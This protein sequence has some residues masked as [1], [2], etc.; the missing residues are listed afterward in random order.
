MNIIFD[1]RL[2]PFD[3]CEIESLI[4]TFIDHNILN[5]RE[6]ERLQ[7]LLYT[8]EQVCSFHWGQRKGKSAL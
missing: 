8:Y 4:Q 1:F 3:K 6:D 5:S 7:Q 2:N